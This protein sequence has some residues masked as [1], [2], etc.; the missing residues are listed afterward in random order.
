MLSADYFIEHL[1][2]QPHI[3]GGFYKECLRSDRNLWSSIYFLLRNGEVSHF[4]RLKSDE[5]WYFHCGVPLTIYMILPT[6]ELVTRILGLS[7]DK[8]E[9]PK[10]LVP[11]GTLFSFAQN[12]DRFD[13][14]G[15]MVSPV[16]TFADFVLFARESLQ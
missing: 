15:C 3:E 10:L 6:G 13:L 7:L 8:C 9:L 1:Q 11:A 12:E 5:V 2:M 16:F 14:V 4:H